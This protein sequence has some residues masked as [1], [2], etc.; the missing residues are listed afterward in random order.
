MDLAPAKTLRLNLKLSHAR[1]NGIPQKS[2]L[3]ELDF[4]LD[5]IFFDYVL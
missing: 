2:L 4:L 5:L 1:S 3:H